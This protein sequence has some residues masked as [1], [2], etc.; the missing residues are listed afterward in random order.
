[1]QHAAGEVGMIPSVEDPDAVL[2][3]ARAAGGTEVAAVH[4]GHGWRVGRIADPSGHHW[5]IGRRLKTVAR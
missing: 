5:E 3:R 1:M 4:D 2:A